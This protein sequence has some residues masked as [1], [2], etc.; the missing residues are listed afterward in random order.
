MEDYDPYTLFRSGNDGFDFDAALAD[1]YV[2]FQPAKRIP[3][4]VVVQPDGEEVDFLAPGGENDFPDVRLT[5]SIIPDPNAFGNLAQTA[6]DA[7]GDLREWISQWRPSDYETYEEFVGSLGGVPPTVAKLW[8][9][10][11][12][13]DDM[14]NFTI[15]G[16]PVTN[17]VEPTHRELEWLCKNWIVGAEELLLEHC[18]ALASTLGDFVVRTTV[19]GRRAKVFYYSTVGIT[20]PPS[21][22]AKLRRRCWFPAQDGGRHPHLAIIGRPEANDSIRR[23]AHSHFILSL[24]HR[25]IGAM[26]AVEVTDRKVR[27]TFVAKKDTFAELTLY[28]E[29]NPEYNYFGVG[30][31]VEWL[32]SSLFPYFPTYLPYLK[33]GKKKPKP[34]PNPYSKAFTILRSLPYQNFQRVNIPIKNFPVRL[35]ADKPVYCANGVPR[36]AVPMYIP[37]ERSDI[38]AQMELSTYKGHLECLLRTNGARWRFLLDYPTGYIGVNT[39]S[40]RDAESWVNDDFLPPSGLRYFGWAILRNSKIVNPLI[41]AAANRAMDSNPQLLPHYV[42]GILRAIGGVSF[43]EWSTIKPSGAY[44]V[45][46]DHWGLAPQLMDI[47]GKLR[48]VAPYSQSDQRLDDTVAVVPMI[49]SLEWRGMEMELLD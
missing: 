15:N 18:D 3:V 26:C 23:E 4:P 19:R 29:Q 32:F 48:M 14:K 47:E 20:L 30:V 2:N 10:V 1:A 38:V 41:T 49:S 39:G 40:D 12:L 43:N 8:K 44:W 6:V 42:L 25:P 17:V 16:N 31:P 37:R 21:T 36:G 7:S 27:G 45:V 5:A 28:G 33:T 24:T 22:E 34:I 11:S 35:A 46:P 13:A 9:E